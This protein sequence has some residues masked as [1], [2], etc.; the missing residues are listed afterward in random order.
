VELVV[1]QFE[2]QLIGSNCYVVR[3]ASSRSCLIIDPGTPGSEQLLAFL[4][5]E[6]LSPAAILLTH[7]HFD[8]CAGVSD[9]QLSHRAT[10]YASPLTLRRIANPKTNLSAYAEVVAPF[11]VTG[12]GQSL[13][14]GDTVELCGLQIEC[15]ETPGH[16]PGGMCFKIGNEMFAGDTL[17]QVRTPVKLPGGD[18]TLLHQSLAKLACSL[19]AGDRINPGHG[20]QF[21]YQ[22]KQ[23]LL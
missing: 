20:K 6:N 2:N 7:E 10:V 3:T 12:A 23:S 1:R 5:A 13:L 14:D 22:V 19:A 17:M 16:S 21:T 9:V 15:I 11:A 8:H 4:A 18:H